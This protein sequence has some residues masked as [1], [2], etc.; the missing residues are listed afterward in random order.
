MGGIRGNWMGMVQEFDLNI[1]PAKLV[2]GKG[3]CKLAAKAQDQVNEYYGWENEME[4]WCGEA[5]YISLGL[6]SWYENLTYLLHH[7]T[8]P[9]NLNP[10]ERKALRLKSAQYR[11]INSVL[12]WINYDGVLLICL[13][14][15]DVDKVLK[16]LHDGPVGGYFA[17]N[18]TAHKILR[19][20]YYWPTLFKDSHNYARNCKTCQISVGREKRVAVPPQLVTVSRPFEKWGL[21]I[22]G[23]I[24]PSSSKQHKYI[25]TATVYFKKWEKAI[26]LTHVNEKVVIQFIEQKLITRFGVPSVLVF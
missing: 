2:E 16:E 21:D 6:D 13:E 14:R 3:L 20:N 15:E 5:A 11:L 10:R 7:G 9:K 1:K 22:I 24:T 19:A 25:L 12:F 17:G 8:C 23:E 26:P 18:I 4:L